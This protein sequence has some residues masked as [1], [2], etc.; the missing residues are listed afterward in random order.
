M[1]MRLIPDDNLAYPVLIRAATGYSGSGFFLNTD[2]ASY[3]IT[4]RHVLF[5]KV[6]GAL[7]AAQATLTSYSRNPAETE[8]NVLSLDL[9][10]LLAAGHVEVDA[11]Q[12]VAVLR[13]GVP[14]PATNILNLVPGVAVNST[15]PSGILGVAMSTVRTYNDVMIANEVYLFGYPVS[16]GM[17]QIP[18]I[19]YSRP[20]LRK[21][22]VAGKNDARRTIILDCPVY[23]GNSGGP[24]LEAEEE[25]FKQR[26][27][28]IGVVLEFV[29][30][31]HPLIGQPTGQGSGVVANSGYSVVAAMDD[32]VQLVNAF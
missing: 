14:N 15:A 32:V 30:T 3:L 5:D 18:Q 23:P 27:F 21:G 10:T 12:D 25:A 4:A 31:V 11:A 16:L 22:I 13:Y 24:V 6:S 1:G 8:Q 7:R 28:I 29:P 2:R 26:F 19:D 9:A 20:L 17:P